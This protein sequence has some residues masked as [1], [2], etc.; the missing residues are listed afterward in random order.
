M[1]VE[2]EAKDACMTTLRFG[3]IGKSHQAS[4]DTINPIGWMA[5]A[6]RATTTEHGHVSTNLCLPVGPYHFPQDKRKKEKK[7]I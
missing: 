1:K 4:T 5:V 2:E 3:C 6:F 7:V